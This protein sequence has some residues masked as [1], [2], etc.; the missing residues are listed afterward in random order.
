MV[1]SK[2]LDIDLLVP[3]CYFGL[4]EPV[5]AIVYRFLYGLQLEQ[6]RD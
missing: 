4:H 1:S 2:T 5:M 6:F 3:Q